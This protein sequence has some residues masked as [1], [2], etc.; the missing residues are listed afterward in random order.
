MTQVYDAPGKARKQCPKCHKYIHARSTICPA[1]D[2]ELKEGARARL[3]DKQAKADVDKT[4]G[5]RG[6]KQCPT[7]RS[8]V[9]V[10]TRICDCG[11][12][13]S[14]LGQVIKERQR[15][16]HQIEAEATMQAVGY[17]G[18]KIIFVPA[19]APPVTLPRKI[20][21]T[22]MFK[23]CEDVLNHFLAG[24]YFPSPSCMRY[25]IRQHVRSDEDISK[26]I[27]CVNEWKQDYLDN[28]EPP[29][30]NTD[31]NQLAQLVES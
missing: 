14:V 17:G 25:L 6:L 11:N 16:P 31:W 29:A 18:M 12:D 2:Y 19:G 13:F 10:R 22:T 26:A 27:K 23:W 9:G 1:C 7:C 8:Y 28:Y 3:A 4:K 30:D 24:R 15:T 21:K 20:T 5:G